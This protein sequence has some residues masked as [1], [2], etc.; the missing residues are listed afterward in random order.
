MPNAQF[1]TEHR[2]TK[3]RRPENF[4]YSYRFLSD[5]QDMDALRDNFGGRWPGGFDNDEYASA[6][7]LVG[8]GDYQE[9][10]VSPDSIPN[11]WNYYYRIA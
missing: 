7:V 4:G 10:W 2:I 1:L 5:S 8:D 11:Y 6:F 9:I 3:V